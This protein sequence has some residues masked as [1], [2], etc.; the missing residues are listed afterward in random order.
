[1][2]KIIQKIKTT[3]ENI[4][5]VEK[6]VVVGYVTVYRHRQTGEEIRFET[7]YDKKDMPKE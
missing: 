1:M 2:S 6:E 3:L 5:F 7:Y 4:I